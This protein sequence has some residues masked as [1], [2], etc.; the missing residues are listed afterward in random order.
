M[1]VLLYSFLRSGRFCAC[2]F[3]PVSSVGR[4]CPVGVSCSAQTTKICC[5]ILI[6]GLGEF[7]QIQYE[8][9]NGSNFPFHA[10][11]RK[12]LENV[13]SHASYAGFM[14]DTHIIHANIRV[15]ENSCVEYSFCARNF[16]V[17][18]SKYQVKQWVSHAN[19]RG[20]RQYMHIV[21][22]I[23]HLKKENISPPR[24]T[25]KLTNLSF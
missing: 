23:G 2:H 7:G 10:R 18:N 20:E 17:K 15:I 12:C 3:G 9:H 1:W 14:H 21:Q 4:F 19:Q 24:L 8:C 25:E 11:L 6:S 5:L 16:Q 22:C 13:I